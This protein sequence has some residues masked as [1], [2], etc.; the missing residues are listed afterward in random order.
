M[1]A[2]GGAVDNAPLACLHYK[3]GR[4]TAQTLPVP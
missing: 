1:R 3:R 4:E 2:L